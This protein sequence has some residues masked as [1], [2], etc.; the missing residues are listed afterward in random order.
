MR[1]LEWRICIVLLSGLLAAC[2][3]APVT[4]PEPTAAGAP[5]APL[6]CETDAQCTVKNVGN[7]CG[8]FLA[9]VHVD[10]AVDVAAVKRRCESEGLSSV[11]GQR[12]IAGCRCDAG[13]CVESATAT[14]ELD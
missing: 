2:A 14:T 3:P 7:C 4:S 12:D 13:Q 5:D 10:Q 11:C 9:C 8:E 6:A 1:T